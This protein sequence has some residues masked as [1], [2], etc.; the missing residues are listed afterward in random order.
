VNY[1]YITRQEIITNFVE[2][3]TEFCALIEQQEA[4][5]PHQF[6]KQISKILAKLYAAVMELV[7]IITDE[8]EII[9]SFKITEG[10]PKVY[11]GIQSKLGQYNFYWEVFN[12]LEEDEAV[13]G[14]LRDDLRDIYR[15]I[16]E[17][18]VA[19]ERGHVNYA[20]WHW[21][22][23]FIVHWGDHLVDAL[24][25]LHRINSNHLNAD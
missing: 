14:D 4:I 1:N 13:V 21:K 10:V 11:Q 25:V 18:F 24:R 5:E 12:P 20:I 6:I 3:V 19:F 9:E 23:H 15:D 22:F 8:Q 17:G 16:K 7:N 2:I